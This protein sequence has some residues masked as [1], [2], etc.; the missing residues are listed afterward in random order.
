MRKHVLICGN[1]KSIQYL[2]QV[3]SPLLLEI[4]MVDNLSDLFRNIEARPPLL[5]VL[6]LGKKDRIHDAICPRLRSL[7]SKTKMPMMVVAEK[8]DTALALQA[9][10]L[11][12]SRTIFEPYNVREWIVSVNALLFKKKHF[13]CLGGGTGL[14][15]LLFGLKTVPNL[16]LTSI[17]SMSDDGGSSGRIRISHGILP[18][19]DIRRS[20]VALSS[21]P[22]LMNQVIQHRFQ[23]G[24][25]FRGHSFGNLFLTALAEI[26]GSMPEA[27]RALGDILNIEGIVLPVTSTL[28]DLEA[29][30]EDGTVI[31]G[32]SKID[33]ASGRDPNLR[34]VDL[35]HR[36]KAVH[37]PDAYAALLDADFV[38]I[39]PGDLFTSV[40]A[41]L[42]IKGIRE[43]LSKTRAKKIYFCNLM[44]KPGET[45]RYTA[46][47]HV[48][49]IIKYLGGDYLDYVFLSNTRLSPKAVSAYARKKQDPVLA[50]GLSQI[51]KI[52]KAQLLVADLGYREEL[53]RHDSEKIRFEIE[54]L[55]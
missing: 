15:H 45:A 4:E 25:G 51:R 44:T 8:R 31:C 12:V 5:M 35:R 34:I 23:K 22:K 16:L 48:R 26:K 43:A 7:A 50:E 55:L 2:A 18:P 52:T 32:E 27:I 39:G 19:G 21:A 20:L 33:L 46:F 38:T 36:P 49:E 14:Y 41:N 6:R 37:N 13:A 28:T 24:D 17:V 53:V 3:L 1:R 11:G 30:F 29:T 40:I 47:D 42:N 9:K 10:R 54:R